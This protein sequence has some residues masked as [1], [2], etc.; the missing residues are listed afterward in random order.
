MVHDLI[1]QSM[2]YFKSLD[3]IM[4]IKLSI[5]I[6]DDVSKRELLCLGIEMPCRGC[7]MLLRIEVTVFRR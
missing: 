4:V 6:R 2:M 5:L 7:Q 3:P 1:V